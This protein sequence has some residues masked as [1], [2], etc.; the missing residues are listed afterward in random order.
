MHSAAQLL[1]A[2]LRNGRFAL[3]DSSQAVIVF[4]ARGLIIQEAYAE[5]ARRVR[6]DEFEA[7]TKSGKSM[8]D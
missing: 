8:L 2:R 5:A 7:N 4:P 1:K 6:P 3:A